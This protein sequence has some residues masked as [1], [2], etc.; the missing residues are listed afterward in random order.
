MLSEP[1]QNGLYSRLHLLAHEGPDLGRPYVDTLKGS[2][3]A[4]MKEMRF[5]ADGGV[6][7]LAFA[8][9]PDRKAILLVAGD[10]GGKD[11]KR[12]YKRFIRKADQRFANHL[13]ALGE[14]E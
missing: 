2:S 7:R 4:N 1:V 10:K 8:F 9:D 5:D 11:Q 14:D 12:F 3:F 13:A 6:W